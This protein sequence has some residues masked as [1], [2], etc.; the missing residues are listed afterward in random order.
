[1]GILP[2]CIR[3]PKNL[4]PKIPPNGKPYKVKD[5]DSWTSLAQAKSMDVWALIRFNYPT[6][7]SSIGDAAL[8]VNWYLQ[9]YVGC[10]LLTKDNKNY[11]FSTA[12]SPG[13]IYFPPDAPPKQVTP[14]S[15]APVVIQYTRFDITL[16]FMYREMNTNSK[17]ALAQYLWTLNHGG[18][19]GAGIPLGL[20]GTI[21]G[22]LSGKAAAL[23]IWAY[24]VKTGGDWDHKKDLRKMLFIP[25]NDARFPFRGDPDHEIHYDIWSNVHYGYVG[26]AAGF[27]E[28]ELQAGH[29]VGGIAGRTDPYDVETVQ[30]GLDLWSTYG[31]NMSMS[32]LHQALLG[33]IPKLLQIQGTQNYKNVNGTFIHIEPITDGF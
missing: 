28:W 21:I 9:N 18:G 7:P 14:P 15:P 19:A 23:A 27:S 5:G 24:K 17:G 30:L 32:Q 10:K 4:S 26:R 25:P 33:R 12:A 16:A 2:S 13:T 1:M 3:V 29:Q 8:E 20:P 31:A 6:L 11:C 22:G